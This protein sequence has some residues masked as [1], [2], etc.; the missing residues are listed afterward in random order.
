MAAG[1][2]LKVLVMTID[3]ARRLAQ[4][5]GLE[6]SDIEAR[7]PDQDFR[8]ELWAAMI[9][10]DVIFRE[11]L[12]RLASPETV[13]RMLKNGLYQQLASTLSGSQEFTSIIKLHEAAT[14]GKYDLVI[15]DTPPAAHALDFLEAPDRIGALFQRHVTQW[16]SLEGSDRSFVS[17]LFFKS[18]KAVLQLFQKVTGAHFI[19][20]LSDFFNG[21][22]SIQEKIRDKSQAAKALLLGEQTGFILITGFDRAKLEEG[23]DFHSQLTRRGYHLREVI[24]NRAVPEWFVVMSEAQKAERSMVGDVDDQRFFND[25]CRYLVEKNEM[26]DSYEKTSG[27]QVPI[28]RLIEKEEAPLGLAGL[29]DLAQSLAEGGVKWNKHR[30]H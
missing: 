30:S 22:R 18:T 5:L 6:S 14:S 3:P 12:E 24:V 23:R 26:Y 25:Y 21:L 15:L 20:E 29:T 28:V 17:R 13:Q 7:V 1:S 4:S 10:R 16:F 11:F 9:S 27:V 2:G 19:E 8:G